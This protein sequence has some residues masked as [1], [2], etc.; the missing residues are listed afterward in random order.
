[1]SE[2]PKWSRITR[3]ENIPLHEGRSVSV[4]GQEI[5]IFHLDGGRFLT[6]ENRCPHKNGPLCDGIVAGA[7]VV[8]PL[9]GRRFDLET[10]VAVRASEAACVATYPTRVED[11]IIVVDIA[12]AGRAFQEPAA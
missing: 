3:V 8:C 10:G 7:V 11:G 6:I 5:A 12:G 2:T 4:D 1:M 9:H